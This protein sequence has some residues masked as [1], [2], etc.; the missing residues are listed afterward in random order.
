MNGDA[1]DDVSP[2]SS[3]LSSN[4]EGGG[5]EKVVLGGAFKPLPN[6]LKIINNTN[7]NDKQDNKTPKA[8]RYMNVCIYYFISLALFLH[9]FHL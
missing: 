9:F 6:K 5:G 4:N 1:K 3:S 2:P 7:N 8:A